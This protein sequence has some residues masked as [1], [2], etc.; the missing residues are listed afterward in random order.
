MWR[1]I[2]E[3]SPGSFL[4]SLIDCLLFVIEP[5]SLRSSSYMIYI[6]YIAVSELMHALNQGCFSLSS[7]INGTLKRQLRVFRS[8]AAAKCTM[9]QNNN[10]ITCCVQIQREL[11]RR[12][13]TRFLVQVVP[14]NEQQ[15]THLIKTPKDTFMEYAL[16]FYS[17]VKVRRK[18]ESCVPLEN[19]EFSV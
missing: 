13:Q 17:T 12:L 14:V 8:R 9:H 6:M 3:T 2:V 10:R 16:S 1:M 4:S 7:R 15:F 11:W 19:M 18:T 5:A